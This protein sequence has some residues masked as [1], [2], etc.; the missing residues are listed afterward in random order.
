MLD[1]KRCVPSLT[2]RGLLVSSFCQQDGCRHIGRWSLR[3]S[4][5]SGHG[6]IVQHG[7]LLYGTLTGQKHI[8]PILMS[9]RVLRLLAD[10]IRWVQVYEGLGFLLSSLSVISSLTAVCVTEQSVIN[11]YKL[12]ASACSMFDGPLIL[13]GCIVFWVQ[14]EGGHTGPSFWLTLIAGLLH[15]PRGMVGMNVVW[16]MLSQQREQG[17]HEN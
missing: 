4:V 14:L 16:K 3:K 11:F 12:L 2:C 13:A 17:L 15:V 1:M 9:K 6:E 10:L 8:I 5:V 7:A